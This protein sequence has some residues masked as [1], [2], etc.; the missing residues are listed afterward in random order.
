MEEIFKQII[1]CER[2][3]GLGVDYRKEREENLGYAYNHKPDHTK[4]LWIL[5]SP[6]K[7][8]P[9]R[10][11]YRPELTRYD[12]L[13]REV[14]KSLGITPTDPKTGGLK[15]F[16]ELGHFLIDIAKCPVDKDNSHLKPSMFKNCAGIFKKEVIYLNPESILIIK[17][18]NYD[19]IN[20]R[21]KEMGFGDRVIN[22]KPIP[23][24]GSGQQ[25][26][27]REAIHKYIDSIKSN[28]GLKKNDKPPTFM[29]TIMTDFK[30]F[31]DQKEYYAVSREYAKRKHSFE[32]ALE[33]VRTQISIIKAQNAKHASLR[34][35]YIDRR[36]KSFHSLILK[37]VNYKIP[38]EEIFIS[39]TD[40]VGIRVVINN[41][42]DIEPLIDEMNKIPRLK[43]IDRQ[44][45]VDEIGYR[46]VH[47][48]AN[49]SLNK[50]NENQDAVQMEIQIRS[51]L[52]DAW[53]ILSHHDVYKN[54]S[55]LPTLAKDI[56]ENMSGMLRNLDK[57]ADSFRKEI[58]NKVEPPNDL[59]DEAPLDREGIAFLYYE[60]FGYPPEE[61]EVQ[62]LLRVVDEYGIKTVGD[63][64][65]GFEYEVLQ[66]L[67]KIHNKRFSMIP[68]DNLDQ[69]KFGLLYALHGRSS[70]R[71]Y[72]KK[73][74][75]DWAEI[76]ATARSEILSAMPESFDKFVEDLEMNGLSWDVWQA[77]GE[78]GGLS[79][80][81]IC[82][83]DIIDP[84][85]AAE[86]VLEFYDIEEDDLDFDLVS[87]FTDP[88][89]VDAPETVSV[90]N[91]S[92]CPYCGWQM[93]K[94]D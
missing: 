33:E 53:A 32:R 54:K 55:D 92:L 34:I 84:Y 29:N 75:E 44:D 49:Y 69:F 82:G 77:I 20:N 90:Y 3:S 57:L 1:K 46:A 66:N 71:E 48:S 38:A 62:F 74:E 16:Q 63:A 2:C 81:A 79:N 30:D 60:L 85:S 56:S 93:S 5:E 36:I 43:I 13:Y 8:D 70:Y 11:F 17:S 39:I 88:W 47:L 37:A 21:L 91:S 14:M 10:Y 7:S 9:P 28:K 67:E 64:R 50:G 68:I 86:A 26:R 41:L 59:A 78:L 23:Y 80:C 83:A 15:E 52:Q 72:R 18:P 31:A 6:P 19:L 61:Y 4:V 58:E 94:D 51:L 73:I 45:H 24:P 76:E 12:G 40:I 89:G 35:A 87:L 25:V 65:R 42:K 22:D 27:F